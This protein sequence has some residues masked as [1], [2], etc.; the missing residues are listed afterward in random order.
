MLTKNL[1]VIGRYWH[2]YSRRLTEQYELLGPDLMVLSF[3]S[4]NEESTQDLICTCLLLDKT[5][6]AKSAFRLEKMGYISRK[7]ND[8]DRREKLLCLT[9]QGKELCCHV[10]E[11][12][13]QWEKICL[14]GFTAQEIGI[15]TALSERAAHNAVEY[16]RRRET[17]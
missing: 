15:F 1:S 8:K 10:L 5:T 11:E 12:R 13:T 2:W 14:E 7:V 6:T 17:I 16:R 4:S 9:Q 3:L